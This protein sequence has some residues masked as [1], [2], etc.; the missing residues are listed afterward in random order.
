MIYLN[1]YE[2]SKYKIAE[3]HNNSNRQLFKIK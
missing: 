3:N 2:T 1:Y